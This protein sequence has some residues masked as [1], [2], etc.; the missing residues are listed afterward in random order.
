M[1]LVSCLLRAFIE[2]V[3]NLPRQLLFLDNAALAELKYTVGLPPLLVLHH[4]LVRSPV[5]LPHAL[6]GWAE[7]E[8]VRWVEEHTEEEAW[9]LVESDLAHWEKMAEAE[10]QGA[11]ADGAAEYVRLAR[12]VL[13]EAQGTQ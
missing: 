3:V 5:P 4:I 6:H 11:D 2:E 12:A 10:G 13:A 7:A 9:T 1:L 8:Y